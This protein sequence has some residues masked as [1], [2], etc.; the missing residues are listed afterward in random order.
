M[1]L[2]TRPKTVFGP[3]PELPCD[4]LPIYC[5]LQVLVDSDPTSRISAIINHSRKYH[6]DMLFSQHFVIRCYYSLICRSHGDPPIIT[7]PF[8]EYYANPTFLH[9]RFSILLQLATSPA[10]SQSTRERVPWDTPCSM[11]ASFVDV[12]INHIIFFRIHDVS[13][14]RNIGS[15]SIPVER[16]YGNMPLHHLASTM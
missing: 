5:G 16:L 14:P 4:T 1:K 8:D 12:H 9:S 2:L 6:G 15:P 7:P 3:E 10:H 11:S 13:V